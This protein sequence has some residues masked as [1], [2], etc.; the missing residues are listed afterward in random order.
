MDAKQRAAEA[1]LR[2][3]E[4]GM[5]VGLG[6]GSTADFFLRALAA[7]IKG[8]QLRDIRGVPTSSQSER[9]AIELGIPLTTLA[10]HPR[11]DVTIDGA[12]EV[13]PN[14]DLIKGLGGALLREKIVAQNS[15]KLVI[16]VGADKTVQKLGSKSMLPVE[17][18]QFAHA[19]QETFLRSLG[20]QPVLRR[21][22]NGEA[23]VTDNGNYI[24]DCRFSAGIGAP[25]DLEH[26]L[27]SRAGIVETGLFLGI[28]SVALIAEETRVEERF[29]PKITR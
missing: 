27:R 15:A 16:I 13:A 18:A 17:V 26:S 25:H 11:P 21:A 3:V 23:F 10:E 1:A 19:V 6:T 4:S 29:A 28:A 12:D 9:R 14:L 5:V 24:Y 20:G 22:A 2:F 8:K 7:A